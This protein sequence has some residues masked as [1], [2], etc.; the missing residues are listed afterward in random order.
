[1]VALSILIVGCSS[2]EGSATMESPSC[3]LTQGQ[4]TETLSEGQMDRTVVSRFHSGPLLLGEASY[5]IEGDRVGFT[6]PTGDQ[7]S[8]RAPKKIV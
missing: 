2:S 5:A 3:T 6:D 1:M 4:Q 7:R 8:L